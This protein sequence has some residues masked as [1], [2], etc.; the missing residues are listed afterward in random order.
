M[1]YIYLIGGF[2]IAVFLPHLT[3][4]SVSTS[5]QVFFQILFVLSGIVGFYTF[6]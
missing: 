2:V 4:S 5:E 3:A 1:A 6:K